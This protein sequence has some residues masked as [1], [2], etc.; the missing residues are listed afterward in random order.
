MVKTK[1]INFHTFNIMNIYPLT[2]N[3]FDF[4]YIN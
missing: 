3:I 2:P 1:E 4:L